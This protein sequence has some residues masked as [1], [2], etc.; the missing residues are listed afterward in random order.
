MDI[1][2]VNVINED[3]KVNI[4]SN[5]L[6]SLPLWFGI[7]ESNDEY[8]ANVKNYA[9]IKIT[10]GDNIIGFASIKD[11]NEYV[12]ELY[13]MGIIPQYHRRGIGKYLINHIC[14]I[15]KESNKKYL[16]VKTLA[17]EKYSE[18]YMKTRNFYLE[19]GFIPI[20]ILYNEWGKN[21][22]CL[23]MLKNIDR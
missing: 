20:D 7:P 4:C 1:H 3:D 12:S 2:F 16:E 23:I 18:E 22:P 17:A 19:V 10:D 15:L 8:C 14:N 6:E 21:N 9:F 13:V 11:N 5:I